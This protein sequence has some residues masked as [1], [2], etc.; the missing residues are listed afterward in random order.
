MVSFCR[1]PII[2]LLHA[3]ALP[4][5]ATLPSAGDSGGLRLYIPA[6]QEQSCMC[7]KLAKFGYPTP[8]MATLFCYSKT[9]EAKD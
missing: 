4:T 1:F 5:H 6:D 9:G 2:M 3:N 8:I 7:N